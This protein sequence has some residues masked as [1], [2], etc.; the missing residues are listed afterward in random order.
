LFT[1]LPAQAHDWEAAEAIEWAIREHRGSVAL[2][3]SFGGPTGLVA[4][5][6]VMRFDRSVP[7][8]YLDTGLL[9]PQ[10]Y[11]L[12]RKVSVR[13]GIE[14]IPVRP[15]LS[16]YE[17]DQTH[18]T[19][20]WRR[21]PDRCCELRKVQPQAAY[22]ADFNVWITGLRANH[23]PGRE[24]VP[25]AEYDDRFSIVKLNP[26]AHWS[27]D[28]IWEYVREFD[29]DYNELNDKGYPSLGCV[30]CTSQ[31]ADGEDPRAGRWRGFGKRECGLHAVGSR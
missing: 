15:E 26:L 29:L 12:A 7:V 23:S 13:Y 31:V 5:D 20:L 2:S 3:C 6:L 14:P 28:R 24:A 8:Y 30:P 17:Q 9:F 16:V 10:T 18:G 25:T 19:A 4:L 21:N 22:L 11:Q 1:N 27:D